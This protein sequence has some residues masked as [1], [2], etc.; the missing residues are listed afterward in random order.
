METRLNAKDGIA[1]K[2][3]DPVAYFAVGVPTKGTEQFT[4]AWGGSTWW[5]AS[6]ANRE[7]FLA[8]PEHFVPQFGGYCSAGK[9]LHIP[10]KGSPKRWRIENDQLFLQANIVSYTLHGMLKDRIH[11]LAEAPTGNDSVPSL[12]HSAGPGVDN[13]RVGAKRLSSGQ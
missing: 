8:D 1:L 7:A 13:D 4:A 2:G 6:E 10:I 5:F 11:Q 9:A 12:E 3:Y